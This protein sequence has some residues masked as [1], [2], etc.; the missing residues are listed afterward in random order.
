MPGRHRTKDDPRNRLFTSA[1]TGPT[2]PRYGCGMRVNSENVY[3]LTVTAHRLPQGIS[4]CRS[5]LALAFSQM[6]RPQSGRTARREAFQAAIAHA[7][8][9]AQI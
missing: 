9:S 1:Q 4:A 7:A 3:R 8:E 5:A 2:H 6:A